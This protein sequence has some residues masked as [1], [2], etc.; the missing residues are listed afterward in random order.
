MKIR[1]SNNWSI[2]VLQ[3]IYLCNCRKVSEND[4]VYVFFVME[5]GE[6]LLYFSRYK[7]QERANHWSVHIQEYKLKVI[8]VCLKKK[9]FWICD[10][11]YMMYISWCIYLWIS[12]CVQVTH[13]WSLFGRCRWCT[14]AHRRWRWIRPLTSSEQWLC[15]VRRCTARL[16]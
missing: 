15:H 4:S 6:L 14:A 1:L 10:W 5:T 16:L 9:A 3:F 13:W 7:L 2:V 11:W 12:V 8:C